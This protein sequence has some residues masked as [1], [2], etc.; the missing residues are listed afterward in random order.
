MTSFRTR[1]LLATLL[2][3]GQLGGLLHGLEH[4]GHADGTAHR[5][6]GHAVHAHEHASHAE[7]PVSPSER[8]DVLCGLCLLATASV[9]LVDTANTP[10]PAAISHGLTAIAV[11]DP[12]PYR[13]ARSHPA[14]GPPRALS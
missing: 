5:A 10:W 3:L 11:N 4:V 13:Q 2:L 12:P 6:H 14:R 7:E 9:A 8:D 1:S